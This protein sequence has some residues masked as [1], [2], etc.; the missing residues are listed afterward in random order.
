MK[1]LLKK[2]WSWSVVSRIVMIGSFFLVSSIGICAS[3]AVISDIDDQIIDEDSATGNLAF[4]VTNI[5]PLITGTITGY[6]SNTNL[7]PDVNIVI[8][9][10]VTAATVTVT[11]A[12]NQYGIADIT[13]IFSGSDASGATNSFQME[14]LSVNDMPVI[15]L[16]GSLI[17][18]EDT[19][20]NLAFTVFDVEDDDGTL[21]VFAEFQNLS[22]TSPDLFVS[23][24][25]G[26]GGS[27]SNRTV[28]MM[29]SL[30]DNGDSVISIY[31]VDSD[32][33][34]NKADI[35]VEV[36]PVPDPPAI[37]GLLDVNIADINEN[38]NIYSGVV[39]VDPDHNKPDP[40]V[41]TL[42]ISYDEGDAIGAFDW[43]IGDTFIDI[44]GSPD[45]IT[46][47][48][49][50]HLFT[51][52]Q[53]VVAPDLIESMDVNLSVLDI[54]SPQN[55]VVAA[56]NVISVLSIND[57]PLVGLTL[58]PSVINDTQSAT[59]FS[60]TI[61]DPDVDE[62][63]MLEITSDDV[64]DVFGSLSS[65]N[66]LRSPAH[67]VESAV[68]SIT[69]TPMI[70]VITNQQTVSFTF[71]LVDNYGGTGID[72]TTLVIN[73]VNNV[74]LI[75]GLP[76]SLL[77]TDDSTPI[78][79]FPV[80]TINDCDRSG[81]EQLD[82]MISV[83][84]PVYGSMS[85]SSFSG[86][87]EDATTWIHTVQFVPNINS[88][89]VGEE[90]LVFLT[91]TVRDTKINEK[92]NSQTEIAVSGVNG[93]PEF[94]GESAAGIIDVV[95]PTDPRPFEGIYVIDD[96]TDDLI[97][98]IALDNEN[99]GT[100]ANTSTEIGFGEITSGYYAFINDLAAISNLLNGLVFNVNSSYPFPASSYGDT[101]F[102]LTVTDALEN[103][104]TV[105][106]RIRLE[107]NSQ[108]FLVT[109]TTD[110]DSVGSIR[111]AVSQASAGDH[112][113]FALQEYPALIRLDSAREKI[114]LS[115]HMTIKGPG[116]DLLRISGDSDGDGS[117]DTQ[118]FRVEANVVIEGLTLESGTAQTGGAVSVEAGGCLTM[119]GCV[120]KDSEA[121]LWGGGIDVKGQLILNN[122]LVRDNKTLFASGIGG[123]GVA[124]YSKQ[125]CSFVNTTFSGNMQMAPTGRDGGGALLVGN[126]DVQV[127]FLVDIKHCTFVAN[128]DASTAKK[129]SALSVITMGSDVRLLNS[130]FADGT[131]RNIQL[132]S[133]T[134][135]SL[136]GNISDD[137][138][139][140]S[141]SGASDETELFT[142]TNDQVRVVD[143]ALGPLTRLEGPT[144]VYPLLTGSPAIDVGVASMVGV[145]QRGVHRIGTPDCGAYE[146][147]SLTRVMINEIL[148]KGGASDFIELYVPRNSRITDLE[149][150]QL[151]VNTNLCHVFAP[152]AI[153]PGSG[154]LLSSGP[155]AI[156]NIAV[157][158]P[159]VL[160]LDL[161]DQGV[162][163]IL[164]SA[165]QIV[166]TSTYV[167]KFPD[168]SHL[169]LSVSS[170]TLAPQFVGYALL[171]HKYVQAPPFGGWDVGNPT[172]ASSPGAD[173]TLTQFG[174]DNAQPVAIDDVV[175]LGEDMLTLI[176]VT[177][178][179]LDA[180]G[181]D[182]VVVTGLPVVA[183]NT[184]AMGASYW[185]STNPVIGYSQ[186]VYY[187]PRTSDIFDSLPNGAEAMD[188]FVYK[189][190]D[191]GSGSISAI[192]STNGDVRVTAEGHRLADG[193]EVQIFGTTDY[194]GTY[195]ISA[196][197]N[198]SFV[199]S[200]TYLQDEFSG[201]WIARTLRGASDTG[202]VS[203]VVVGANDYPVAD[204][205]AFNC[206][207]EDILRI[208]GDPENGVVFDDA[209]L[210]PVPVN[211][212]TGN[213]LINDSDIDTDDD[214]STLLVVG[215]LD[216]VTAI[217]DFS[218][219]NNLTPVTVYSAN[220]GL[221]T[222][223]RIV[224]SGYGGHPSYNGEKDITVLD[225]DNFTIPVVYVDNAPSK[226]IWGRLDDRNRLNATSMLEADVMLD[227]RFDRDETHV[228]YNPRGSAVL[229]AISLGESL[230]DTFYYAIE[231]SH[232][233]VSLG[234]VDITV[235]GVNELPDVGADP[236]SL[237]V[238]NPYI[239]PSNTLS[240]VLGGLTV[241]D[242]VGAGSDT[243]NRG[244]VRV[245]TEGAGEAESVVITDA[246]FTKETE[247]LEI[248]PVDLLANDSDQDSD[249]KLRVFEVFDSNHGVAVTLDV[250]TNI[251]Y[252]ASESSVLDA[253][254][255]GEQVLDFFRAVIADDHGGF[256][257]NVVVVIVEGVND[258]PVSVDDN[259]TIDEDVE[260]FSF[261]PRAVMI[262]NDPSGRFS[263][264]SADPND[265]DVDINGTLPDN[266][267][268]IVITNATLSDHK[269]LY[270]LTN[271]LMTYHPFSSTNVPKYA[272]GP[273]GLY[274]DG[275]SETNRLDDTFVYTVSDQSF[276]FAEND[277]FRVEADG[278]DYLLNVLA[279][280]RNYN[281]RGG[282]I[283]N[284]VVGI[285]DNRGVVSITA[286]GAML[287][288]T[289]E[290]N[291]VGDETF[292][293]T[294]SDEFGNIDKGR[295][296]VRVTRELFNGDLQVN[297][298]AFSVALGEEVSLDVLANDNRLPGTGGALIITRLITNNQPHIRLVNN[299]IQY[300]QTNDLVSTETFSYEAAGAVDGD[301]RVLANVFIRVVNRTKNLPVQ[302][303]FFTVP[304][305]SSEQQL[306]V[307]AND[308]ILPNA[309]NSQILNI[310]G[311]TIGTVTNDTGNNTLK[312]TAKTG[313][314]G[315][316]I[317]GYTI[318][319]NLG[320][321]GSGTV[322]V[323]VGMPVATDDV[324][325]VPKTPGSQDLY[326]L[327]NDQILPGSS[328]SVTIE[329]V[330]G[331]PANGSITD[332]SG[333]LTFSSNGTVGTGTVSYVITD[334][335]RTAEARV[336]INT[337]DDG[338]YATKDTFRV[339]GDSGDITLNVLNNDCS[340]PDT[341]RVLTI[342]AIGTGIDAPD[343]G[344][345]VVRSVDNKTL[346]YTPAPGFIGE[347]TFSYTMTDARFTDE[348][349][350]VINVQMPVIA[351]N[352]DRF[353]VYHEGN[354][355]G[356]FTL[357]VLN[358]DSF[359]P[360]LGGIFE[361]S[362]LGIEG[363][364][365]DVGGTVELSPDGQSI[366]Y[367]PD[368]NYTGSASYTETFTYEAGD[369]TDTRVEGTVEVKVYP[370]SEGRLPEANMD[371]F[372][373][374]RNSTG[375][376]LPV[377]DN[378]SVI[379]D[380][381]ASWTITDVSTPAFGGVA[382]IVGSTIVYTPAPDFVG[383][384]TFSYDIN[385][386]L[387]STVQATVS[388]KVGSLLLNEDVFVV[389]SGST[390]YEL[391]VLL[392]DGILPGPE[393]TPV[394]D[395]SLNAALL[396]T[397]VAE[398]NMMLYTPSE[399]YTGEYPY[400]DTVL[401]GVV[402]DSGLTQT[403]VVSV[404]VVEQGSDRSSSTITFTV[405]G[406][407]DLPVLHNF[408]LVVP[409]MDKQSVSPFS[410][411]FITDVDEWGVEP[412]TVNIRI[413]DPIKGKLINLGIF[414]K[415]APGEY[416]VSNVSPAV[417]SSAIQTLV[418]VPV[419]NRI[420][421]GTIEDTVFTI[422]VWDP[423]V[424]S[425]IRHT[426][427]VRVTPINDTS[428]I[429][430]TV[431]GQTVYEYS[432][433]KPFFGV[434][435]TE[436]DDLT[437]QPLTV[438]VLIDDS[439][440]GL[441]SSLGPFVDMGGGVY[442]GVGLT[443]VQASESLRA[444]V[445]EP[446]TGFR[447][448]ETMPTEITRLTIIVDDQF[449]APVV[450]DTTTVIISDAWVGENRSPWDDVYDAG[451]VKAVGG[452]RDIVAVGTPELNSGVVSLYYRNLGGKENWGFLRNIEPAGISPN[453]EFGSAIAMQE[454]LLVVGAP[455]N[456]SRGSVFI[457]R[458]DADGPDNWGLVTTLSDVSGNLNEHF[459]CSVAI[460]GDILIVGAS[461]A[462]G[463][464]LDSGEVFVYRRD[465]INSDDWIYVES[466]VPND[467]V[468]GTSFGY[469][470]AIHE[471]RIIVG[472]PYDDSLTSRSGA[473]Y[474]FA[475][476][477][478][479]A[480]W[481]LVQKLLP[482][483]NYSGWFGFSVDIYDDVAVVGAPQSN[484]LI[485]DY[486]KTYVYMD[487][488]AGTTWTEKKV[489]SLP[490]SGDRGS[491]FGYSVQV[492]RG[493]L[494]V[495]APNM[496]VDSWL[497]GV[498]YAYKRD[499]GGN[500]NWGKLDHFVDT[501]GAYWSNFG[502][503]INLEDHTLAICKS[504]DSQVPF[505]VDQ[506]N[507]YRFKFNNSPVVLN[508]IFDQSLTVLQPFEMTVGP[509]V[510]AD[511][512]VEET[513]TLSAEIS[514]SWLGFDPST[515]TFSGIPLATGVVDVVLIAT[516]LDGEAA[517]NTFS[518]VVVMPE[519]GVDPHELW[520]AINFG[521]G[522]S[523][524]N[525][526]GMSWA[527][528]EDPDLDD[529]TNDQEYAFGSNPNSF[530]SVSDHI[531][532]LY[533]DPITGYMELV[534]RRR[535]ND[536]SLTF[537]VMKSTD[538]QNWTDTTALF[539]SDSFTTLS[540]E[541]EEVKVILYS[542]A[543]RCF[544]RIFVYQ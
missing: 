308:Y 529:L 468:A 511:A 380:T 24:G 223:D 285:P 80:V 120:V 344:G 486:A 124:L 341:D 493:F 151:F 7:V 370:Q 218:G 100:L 525:S 67:I 270:S 17:M 411:S 216:G 540:L 391:D 266:E 388:V 142:G 291:F 212:A 392:N 453:A 395:T 467:N 297:D 240:D 35:S 494:I 448:S 377:T 163:T 55:F 228:I 406:V 141:Q 458:K 232:G 180:D 401:Y 382:V 78:T 41:L 261:D 60:I 384:D 133:G 366:V 14:V 187:D 166:A 295:V 75:S 397:V 342:T 500:D 127:F 530:N 171:P 98:T 64:S 44:S 428:I 99:K 103:S 79:P 149:G 69:Y 71:S 140:V 408:N 117:P 400:V 188:S 507:V 386:G 332:S 101:T 356:T 111:Y 355:T 336:T 121:V 522:S 363:N 440:H 219:I 211:L 50:A 434:T 337:V 84:D 137:S 447:L 523:E 287:L 161:K 237:H 315:K 21:T 425:P 464:R 31:V 483:C 265:Y 497:A 22:A 390:Q 197:T 85:E 5:A 81:K 369:G 264:T 354:D 321:T 418:F 474:T 250:N 107:K 52:F 346:L 204:E 230:V 114:V 316:D 243:P 438:D 317:F 194:N 42:T 88:V 310:D 371:V 333:M 34:T 364:A 205:D 268:W 477:S 487:A 150:Y 43:M 403:S 360:D 471:N 505:S 51:P 299:M 340:L 54:E 303:D 258:T 198:D 329:S 514:D 417:V 108:N 357:P 191:V 129:A 367:Q 267:L 531:V 361:I 309:R 516:D 433:L 119:N 326:V 70:N 399:V 174:S 87:A 13:L 325:T 105:E 176:P 11:S 159:S 91:L 115:R 170:L 537:A 27:S 419:E 312:Y 472:A 374:E 503:S 158:A 520:L 36:I 226:G 462:N 528:D 192:V 208:L 25:A 492:D 414:T 405:E 293:Y 12:T 481:T 444:L 469:D 189:I 256:V 260:M 109:H 480:S 167:D 454:D 40:E 238:L 413:D 430:G 37:I 286:G 470:V 373:V 148:C 527:P 225:A 202:I 113:T 172:D 352:D 90:E 431:A 49:N 93:A 506:L 478:E 307:V 26:F 271:N 491:Q 450:D 6:S 178:N 61:N 165:G 206:G 279:N 246:W 376:I 501:D 280:D 543:A 351:V 28:T 57:P 15:S 398:T 16:Q 335:V 313:F 3:G 387:G 123:G 63:F 504:A 542:P 8:D 66:L 207:E 153:E 538:L 544:F 441:L 396:G 476:A 368:T 515:G 409:T 473:A 421:V 157:V 393:F 436:I 128:N 498:V 53:N 231:D 378:D 38:L 196:V 339:L 201:S 184:T 435:I 410:S 145:D 314:T 56:T 402:D 241:V 322:T 381:A 512:D 465:P 125:P 272:L 59:P 217:N 407:N 263:Y 535:S 420:T 383:T 257:T 275:L 164:N 181:S 274:L 306:N 236:E 251:Q 281:L 19:T 394:I 259:I 249:D 426:M 248:Y 147:D 132:N 359:L 427:T 294:I 126:S 95:R 97:I 298:D 139:K 112:I 182:I 20:T 116:A 89:A 484:S 68:R 541:V 385:N 18:D 122:C 185:M 284:D 102:T 510:F 353:A 110:D 183:S 213:L 175:G 331:T 446:T 209:A 46:S 415:I 521:A 461:D 319:D 463:N 437:L 509:T 533:V 311:T 300:V 323:Y 536:P 482:S 234:R 283:S 254:A 318:T 278:S 86:T 499:L 432:Q 262:T 328:G 156:T 324:Y 485:Y 290:V 9:G 289:P 508:Q 255:Q 466:L 534:Y 330:A 92:S 345:T 423:Y 82:V 220:H 154:I 2:R 412:L 455:D 1:K 489:L 379:P 513:L 338:V 479:S 365:P 269:A 449:A 229:N 72:S 73:E 45:D 118:I 347:E 32:N 429:S 488:G 77:R 302:D 134:I 442:R 349:K 304:Y 252:N 452:T 160:P 292:T 83:S 168:L 29:P 320:G 517:T 152:T 227:I 186:G 190:A 334:G 143:I 136:G 96:E 460:S 221:L 358:N 146:Y 144:E 518:V 58:S 245:Y 106:V 459:G 439:T 138:A 65:T 247:V 296:T 490:L 210:Y 104:D 519:G 222:G 48:I 193:A 532:S 424:T 74:P 30:N 10:P 288:Y 422:S 94:I 524:T 169:D 62:S 456:L 135:T 244:D 173:T 214:N 389:V 372:S 495:G 502:L 445:F 273:W 162:I 451:Y 195:T 253:L 475:R 404:L 224:I 215:V 199:V 343:H 305:G 362:G 39:V 282:T 47:V 155:V 23:G 350:V 130:I 539:V 4:Q 239:N 200:A 276:I 76:Y 242:A 327:V 277:L 526:A 131:G 233:A 301:V 496:E 457:Y 33:A 348:A 443:A 179:D 235:A 203:I 177:F 416:A 375:N